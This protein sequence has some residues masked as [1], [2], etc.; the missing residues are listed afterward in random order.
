[1]AHTTMNRSLILGAMA[2]TVLLAGCGMPDVGSAQWTSAHQA[3]A[4]VESIGPYLPPMAPPP[5]AND[6]SL[7]IDQQTLAAAGYDNLAADVQKLRSDI[8]AGATIRHDTEASLVTA[9]NAGGR[10][11]VHDLMRFFNDAGDVGLNGGY[12]PPNPTPPVA[13]G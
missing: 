6:M 11:L 3:A 10:A 2:A 9:V 1:M 7:S 12:C 13:C 8:R 4:D 5:P